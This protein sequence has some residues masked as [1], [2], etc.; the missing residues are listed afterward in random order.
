MIVAPSLPDLPLSTSGFA[1]VTADR[2]YASIHE[3]DDQHH[4]LQ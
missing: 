4:L 1:R 2:S 3:K